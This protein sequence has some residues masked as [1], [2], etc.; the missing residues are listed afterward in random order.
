MAE[1]H[2]AGADHRYNQKAQRLKPGL[3]QSHVGRERQGEG[4]DCFVGQ[5]RVPL[6][7]KSPS[8]NH[9]SATSATLCRAVWPASLSTPQPCSRAVDGAIAGAGV[10][11]G[12][13]PPTFAALKDDALVAALNL[14]LRMAGQY[15]NVCPKDAEARSQV[16]AFLD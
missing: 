6:P 7:G 13:N 3:A 2:G 1:V 12:R 8:E 15:R 4:G 9:L 14:A 16:Q 11:L 10:V 5:G